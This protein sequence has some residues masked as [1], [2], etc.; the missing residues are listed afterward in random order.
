MTIPRD[1][2]NLGYV[3]LLL[4]VMALLVLFVYGVAV[5]LGR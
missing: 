1:E 5:E 4:A 3:M 2:R